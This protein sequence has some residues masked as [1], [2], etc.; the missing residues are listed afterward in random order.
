MYIPFYIVGDKIQRLEE[1][2]QYYM[3][4]E[5]TKRFVDKYELYTSEKRKLS[6]NK[7]CR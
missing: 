1:C 2:K 4:L 3:E 7:E 6:L 5:K